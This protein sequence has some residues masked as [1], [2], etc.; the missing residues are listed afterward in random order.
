[1]CQLTKQ[2]QSQ[3]K[4]KF[5]YDV[6]ISLTKPVVQQ[7][8]PVL[9]YSENVDNQSDSGDLTDSSSSS[10]ESIQSSLKSVTTNNYGSD[11]GASPKYLKCAKHKIDFGRMGDYKTHNINEHPGNFHC[12]TCGKGYLTEGQLQNHINAVHLGMIHKC[13]VVDCEAHFLSKKGLNNH[14]SLHN[15]KKD[16]FL[17][18]ICGL[19]FDPLSKL[20]YHKISHS[21]TKE[22]E[23]TWCSSKFGQ[24]SER[25][26]H[27]LL[28]CKK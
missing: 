11:F 28:S 10:S 14:L 22:H 2:K 3:I 9:K 1:M 6:S 23:C 18:N 24:K 4:R 16:V 26:R 25:M 27:Q 21:A 17:C 20:K 5:P 19:D 13:P 7:D 8:V 12:S 15:S